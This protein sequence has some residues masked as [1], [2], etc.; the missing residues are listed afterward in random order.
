MLKTLMLVGIDNKPEITV[1][2]NI[3]NESFISG[4]IIGALATLVIIGIIKFIKMIL[5]YN[6][7]ENDN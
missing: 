1:G 3:D 4:I 5:S 7:N 6:E 2:I